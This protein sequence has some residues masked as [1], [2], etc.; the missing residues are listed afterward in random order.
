MP[1]QRR[2][3]GNANFAEDFETS[4]PAVSTTVQQLV[5]PY[6]AAPSCRCMKC[7]YSGDP[8][9]TGSFAQVSVHRGYI[10]YS[11][12]GNKRVGEGTKPP[13]PTG[14]AASKSQPT[15]ESEAF[16]N[17]FSL[18]SHDLPKPDRDPWPTESTYE[19]VKPSWYPTGRRRG[20]TSRQGGGMENYRRGQL[21]KGVK[22]ESHPR[23]ERGETSVSLYPAALLEI[24]RERRPRRRCFPQESV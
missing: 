15:T 22:K 9:I 11:S 16:E 10:K 5:V 1:A 18:A 19:R 20:V 17:F 7:S 23:R 6:V 4:A 21:G 3:F 8:Y 14:P 24:G 2:G 13:T 12:G